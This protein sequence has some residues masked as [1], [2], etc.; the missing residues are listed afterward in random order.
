MSRG[1]IVIELYPLLTVESSLPRSINRG[2]GG[3]L[4]A[5][6]AYYH[7]IIIAFAMS[8]DSSVFI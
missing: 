2:G 4:V 3:S 1:Q 8:Y 7:A 6:L 5:P